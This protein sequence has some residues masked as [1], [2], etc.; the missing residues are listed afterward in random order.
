MRVGYELAALVPGVGSRSDRRSCAAGCGRTASM[1]V[2]PTMSYCHARPPC[3]NHACPVSHAR[4]GAPGH[5]RSPPSLWT[6]T[7][8]FPRV[9][10]HSNR[11]RRGR[12]PNCRVCDPG[13]AD[14]GRAAG[15]GGERGG[16][17]GTGRG[18]GINGVSSGKDGTITL[19]DHAMVFSELRR[20]T[21]GVAVHK[22]VDNHCDVRITGGILW[23]SCGY[24]RNLK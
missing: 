9:A 8:R 4:T 15:R 2:W 17:D 16:W 1:R 11:L 12:C 21:C 19:G 3:G 10:V 13:G 22:A 18:F 5:A 6:P 23:T 14:R 7:P 24:E 20:V